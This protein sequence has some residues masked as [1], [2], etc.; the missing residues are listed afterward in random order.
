VRNA[1]GRAS[2]EREHG[3][4]VSLVLVTLAIVM[5]DQAT[6][7]WAVRVLSDHAIHV[8]GPIDLR[9]SRNPG[10]AFST[11]TQAT[12]VLAVLALG[13]AAALVHS[14]RRAD[15]RLS[16]I[17]FA[18]VLGGAIGNLVDRFARAPGL[19]RGEVIDFVK[20][21]WWPTFN[22]ADAAI[23]IGAVLLLFWGWRRPREA[24]P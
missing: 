8:V 24:A 15:D 2:I 19:L 21:G 11:F 12:P 16:A 1:A 17:A 20:V 23:T 14:V 4:P 6:K 3:L 22:V 13:L 10:G 9:L 5:A 7:T 18:V